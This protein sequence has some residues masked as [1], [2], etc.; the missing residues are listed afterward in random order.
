M[1][2]KLILNYP[3]SIKKSDVS[4]ATAKTPI[5]IKHLNNVIA[6]IKKMTFTKGYSAKNA[7]NA[8][9]K[10]TGLPNNLITTATPISH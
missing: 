6:A 3:A 10:T 5:K 8:T 1:I 7:N 4:L 9:L 2:R